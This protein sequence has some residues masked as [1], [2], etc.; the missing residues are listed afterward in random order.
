VRVCVYTC[1]K[2]AYKSIHLLVCNVVY[3]KIKR[4]KREKERME[5]RVCV[6]QPDGLRPQWKAISGYIFTILNYVL[7]EPNIYTQW[8]TYRGH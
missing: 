6:V 5:T 1:I 3:V 2:Y 7:Q 4:K 8:L